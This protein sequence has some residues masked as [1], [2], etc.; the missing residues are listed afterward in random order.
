MI[1]IAFAAFT[2]AAQAATSETLPPAGSLAIRGD[3]QRPTT[4][5]AS[6]LA[7]LPM[8]TVTVAF[9]QDG[10]TVTH[11]EQGPYLSAVLDVLGGP[12]YQSCSKNDLLR[13]YALISGRDGRAAVVG[14]GETDPGFGGRQAIL[15][16][17][18]DG[19][20]LIAG[21]PRLIVPGDATAARNIQ[22][23]VSIYTARATPLLPVSGCPGTPSTIAPT[24]GSVIVNGAVANPTTLTYAQMQALPQVSQSVT[25]LSGTT[26]QTHAEQG[27]LLADI[28][29]VA[30]PKFRTNCMNDRQRYY[31]VITGNDGYVGLLSWGDIDGSMGARQSIAAL[32]ED[33]IAQISGPRV[34][35][36][37]DVRGG[38]YVSGTVA[39]TLVRAP[40]QVLSKGC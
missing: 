15:S 1:V 36:P 9:V 22:H 25:F 27:P 16:I 30:K 8:Q 14:R 39:I 37:G 18:E 4:L 12:N 2:G 10:T 11:T 28:L 6:E 21:G 3:I 7:Q 20:F 29:T 23:V 35:V 33:G 13:W 31:I 32:V 17:I 34:T 38:R 40:T 26:P 5:K 24:L 19:R